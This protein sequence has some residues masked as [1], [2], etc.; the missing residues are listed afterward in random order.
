MLTH[1]PFLVGL[2]PAA[3]PCE[4]YR[5]PPAMLA[6]IDSTST[7]L[8]HETLGLV[9]TLLVQQYGTLGVRT[10]QLGV[11]FRFSIG[12]IWLGAGLGLSRVVR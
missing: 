9:S 3:K 8:S 6:R 10:D 11:R 7:Q 12:G 5:H 1:T 4:Y 2:G